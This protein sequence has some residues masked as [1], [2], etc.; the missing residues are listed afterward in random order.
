MKKIYNNVNVVVCHCLNLQ[1][2][3]N[4]NC[5]TFLFNEVSYLRVAFMKNINN[6]NFHQQTSV[7]KLLIYFLGSVPSKQSLLDWKVRYIPSQTSK[8]HSVIKVIKNSC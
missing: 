5:V 6:I 8:P 3:Q 1:F 2:H 4:E 7:L